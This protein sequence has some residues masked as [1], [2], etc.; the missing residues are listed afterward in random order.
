MIG[1]LAAGHVADVQFD[2]GAVVRRIGHR[3]AAAHAVAQDE[4]DVL[5]GVVA[6]GV[7]GGQLQL[8][9]HDVV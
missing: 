9:Y 4:F 3:V 8:D 6:Q 1:E 5:P 7:V 2:A